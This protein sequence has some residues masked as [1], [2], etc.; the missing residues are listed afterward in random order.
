M[1]SSRQ[2]KNK[3][4]DHYARKARQDRYPARSVYKLQEIQQKYKILRKGDRVLDLGCSPG[5]WLIYA[6]A[7]V[8]D[9]GQVVGVDKKPV[10]VALPANVT[11]HTADVFEMDDGVLTV[12]GK[13]FNVVI[14]DMA[15]STT[16]NRHVDCVRSFQLCEAALAVAEKALSRGGAFVCKIFQGEDFEIF[17]R[18][19]KAAYAT[20]KNYKPQ[21]SRKASREIY[22]IAMGKRDKAVP[23]ES[24][25]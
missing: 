2:S 9:G 16:G 10:T 18:Q 4:E 3:W 19:V 6:S 13:G 8:G 12:N 23:G 15:P 20:C 14:S 11:V 25:P 22:V 1:K 7:Q 5:S 21:S 17:L 24:D